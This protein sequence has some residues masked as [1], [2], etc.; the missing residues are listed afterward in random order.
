MLPARVAPPWRPPCCR[1]R[2]AA[3]LQHLGTKEDGGAQPEPEPDQ[4]PA[5]APRQPRAERDAEA[6]V[7]DDRHHRAESLLLA[8][9]EPRL[10][11][12]EGRIEQVHRQ[13]DRQRADVG[14]LHRG[15]AAAEQPRD[16][17]A[18][19]QQHRAVAYHHE[20]HEHARR[21]Q[22]QRRALLVAPAER[23]ADERAG[24]ARTAHWEDADEQRVA[25]RWWGAEVGG[26]AVR[27]ADRQNG[28]RPGASKGAVRAW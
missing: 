21:A 19:R 3:S 4:P 12:V 23:L 15:D 14:C 6:I 7:D 25:A 28:P 22:H 24:R 13:D 16:R 10:E 11:H 26:G 2:L 1:A 5:C 18:Q 8:H 20:H 27:G 9:C 17:S